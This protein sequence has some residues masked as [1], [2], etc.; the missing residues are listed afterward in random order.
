[1]TT[2]AYPNG[3][4]IDFDE[5]TRRILE[6]EG[7][8]CAVTTIGG[9]NDGETDPFLLRRVGDVERGPVALRP[10]SGPG[11]PL[12][13]RALEYRHGENARGVRM[14]P[15]PPTYAAHIYRQTNGQEASLPSL[16]GAFALG[17][18]RDLRLHTHESRSLPPAEPSSL[19]WT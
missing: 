2:F 9:A 15:S 6:E 11:P 8:T 13:P 4:A 16:V 14:P 10:P 12:R 19:P 7:F 5:S 3:R 17:A 1:V 18:S